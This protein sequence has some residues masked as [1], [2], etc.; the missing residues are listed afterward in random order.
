MPTKATS[1]K[2]DPASPAPVYVVYGPEDF[3]KRQALEGILDRLLPD[4]ERSMALSEYD[5]GSKV[6]EAAEVF[7]E[8]RTL[9]FLAERRVVVVRNADAFITKWR[10]HLEDYVDDPSGSGS[11]VMECRSFPGNT[12]LAKKVKAIGEAIACETLKSW[13]VGEWAVSHARQAY[14]LRVDAA[15][16]KLLAEYIGEDLGRV[17]GELQKLSIY[18]GD[19]QR[20]TPDGVQALVGHSREEK[21]WGILDAIGKRDAATA[22]RLWEDVWQTDRA[23]SAR[24]IAGIA[25]TV[26]KVLDAK[27]SG[28]SAWGVDASAF[29]TQDVEDMLCE[30]L[31]ADAAAKIGQ[32]SVRTSVEAFILKACSRPRTRRNAG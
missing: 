26:R 21:V 17:D 10:E 29:G 1:K 15:A 13:K 22:I 19:R 30:L 28:K 27:R 12:R 23:A 9:P 25:Y 2:R 20:V 18:V 8:L 24:A 4:A 32:A 5:A 11:L 7:D 31:D 16:G 14:G 6:P 3:L